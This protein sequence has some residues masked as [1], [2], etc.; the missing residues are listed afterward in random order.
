M[1]RLVRHYTTSVWLLLLLLTFASWL[2]AGGSGSGS[3]GRS[4]GWLSSGVVALA[5]FKVR[6]VGLHF[7]ELKCAPAPL[8]LVFE[9]WVLATYAALICV[10]WLTPNDR[11]DFAY[12]RLCRPAC[13]IVDGLACSATSAP[14]P[15]V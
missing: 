8:R 5:L 4:M 1:I 15:G 11:D 7:M 6:L 2:L 10:Y 14:G 3:G 13:V 12:Y 9:I